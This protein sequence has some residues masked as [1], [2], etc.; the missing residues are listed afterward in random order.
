M[1]RN[2][3]RN[4]YLLQLLSI[5]MGTCLH[6]YKILAK[7]QHEKIPK[8]VKDLFLQLT[9]GDSITVNSFFKMHETVLMERYNSKTTAINTIQI[10]FKTALKNGLVMKKASKRVV[11]KWFK[12]LPTISS[13]QS[14][15]RGSMQKKH[16]GAT[17]TKTMYLGMLWAFN[18]WIERRDF[19]LVKWITNADGIDVKTSKMV[20]FDN[21][22][23]LLEK[24]RT[25][26]EESFVTHLIKDYLYT[27]KHAHLKATSLNGIKCALVS[28]FSRNECELRVSIKSN[29]THRKFDERG[30]TMTL[31]EL[32]EFFTTGRPSITES[33]VYLCKFHRA[34]D[35]S[36]LA[37]R[38]NYDA[39][40][41]LVKWFGTQNHASW[42]LKKC[43]V[44]ISLV[45]VK[46]D[47]RH[48]GCLD[49][50]AITSLQKY[51]D[52]RKEKTG[53]D[54][55][56]DQPLFITK[57]KCPITTGWVQ[58]HFTDIGKRAGILKKIKNDGAQNHYNISS[59]G[60]RAL[61]TSIM[62]ESGC[63][64]DVVEYALGHRIESHYQKQLILYPESIAR[65]LAKGGKRINLFTNFKSVSLHPDV[66]VENTLKFKNALSDVE[67]IKD[68]LLLEKSLRAKDEIFA[69]TIQKE[70]LEIRAYLV[71]LSNGSSVPPPPLAQI[72]PTQI[73]PTQIPPTQIPPTQIPPTQIPPTQIPPTQIPPTQIP[74]TQIPPTQ[75][76]PTQIPPTQIPPTQIPPTQI[77][78]TQIP[79][80]QIPPTQIP[81]TQIPPT[82]IPPTQIPPT[83]IPPTQIPPTQ[84][85][86]TQIPPTQIPPTQI[87]PT[88]IPPTQ[89]APP[90]T[91]SKEEIPETEFCTTSWT[92]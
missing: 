8:K 1:F 35:A 65:E 62:I 79:P 10:T 89:A 16:N 87:P 39:W 34:L 47:Y 52:Y 60:M 3:F 4:V 43:P 48:T 17:T 38:F 68:E 13:W 49:K 7:V 22:E 6:S 31:P 42:N 18:L 58:S 15:L 27:D 61:Y 28:Y 67:K 12:D 2:S 32:I 71:A 23:V 91:D 5:I 37:D 53:E 51:L 74:P 84:I 81:P 54:M 14:Q 69:T 46:T 78:P 76:P 44:P 19:P 25:I 57:F 83:Q 85:P 56:A 36:T 63:R 45:R 24:S 66:T 80:T 9:A 82:Q 59:H 50:D 30:R 41:Q 77:P 11:P 21:V 70:L 73:P 72:P 20:N 55:D 75:I 92:T 33:A 86:P 29:S 64:P 90:S 40:E 88:Q 26:I